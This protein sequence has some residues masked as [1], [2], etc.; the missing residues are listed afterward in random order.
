MCPHL[1]H[2]AT[3]ARTQDISGS[4][5]VHEFTKALEYLGLHTA[6][7]GLPGAGGL[8]VDVVTGLFERY[9]KDKSGHIDYEEFCGAILTEN[10]RMT[11][12]T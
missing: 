7:G 2:L 4:V 9:D 5:D 6:E 11:K 3:P 10:T 1:T 8:P 12:M